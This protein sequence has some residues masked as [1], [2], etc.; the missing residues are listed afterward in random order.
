MLI[1]GTVESSQLVKS[2]LKRRLSQKIGP[3]NVCF[4]LTHTHSLHVFSI[5]P[6]LCRS[7]CNI[8][9]SIDLLMVHKRDREKERKKE[10]ES[11]RDQKSIGRPV[12]A[13]LPSTVGG[14]FSGCSDR[15]A[16]FFLKGAADTPTSIE[17]SE[18]F[19]CRVV[20]VVGTVG[21]KI[22]GSIG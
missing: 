10:T 11:P 7:H 22:D 6:Y 21:K 16:P 5:S 17:H 15:L 20:V 4:T 13:P 2:Q 14:F 8:D 19:S 3:R 9:R 12:L 18:Y 1:K